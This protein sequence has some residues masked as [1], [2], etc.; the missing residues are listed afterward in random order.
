M[1]LEEWVEPQ[2]DGARDGRVDERLVHAH[3]E[4]E[5]ALEEAIALSAPPSCIERLQLMLKLSVLI[6]RLIGFI[7]TFSP[8]NLQTLLERFSR[9]S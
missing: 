7:S 4:V 8:L 5:E 1:H 9:P 2:V 6:E 3:L